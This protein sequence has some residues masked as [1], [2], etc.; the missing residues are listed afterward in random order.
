MPTSAISRDAVTRAARAR[1][2][3][4]PGRCRPVQAGFTLVELLVVLVIMALVAG[5]TGV[6]YDR[7]QRHARYRDTVQSLYT[8]LQQA[9]QQAVQTAQPVAYLFDLQARR[10]GVWQGGRALPDWKGGWPPEL[11]LRLTVAEGA[12]P[13]PWLGLVFLPDGGSTG[14]TIDV[15]RAEQTGVRL[16]IDWLTGRLQQEEWTP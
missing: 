14:G 10:H 1:G 4:L 16:R 9:R 11:D 8:A 6:A 15:L 12:V 13:P 5:A 7:W 3:A 2:A